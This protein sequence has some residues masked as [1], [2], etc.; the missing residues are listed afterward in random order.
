M[1]ACLVN[2]KGGVGKT[3]LA[4]NLASCCARTGNQVCVIDADPQGS[5]LQW[6]SIAG[7]PEFEVL[8]MPGHTIHKQINKLASGFDHIVIDSPPALGEITSS[9]LQA[10]N[11][12]II[13]VGP[14]PLDIWSSR[15]TVDMV[16]G[17]IEKKQKI[18]A[19]LLVCRKIARTRLAREA[20]EALMEYGL[21]VCNTEI[22]QRIAFVEAMLAGQSVFSFAP[23]SPAAE[24]IQ[25]LYNELY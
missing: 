11:L 3:T 4:V 5:L 19:V 25:S 23:G 1:I 21:P 16:R 8:H 6:Q 2:Q 13:P 10:V 22:S 12:S 20:K 24:E 18:R 7:S 15:E 9:I 14:S 17:R